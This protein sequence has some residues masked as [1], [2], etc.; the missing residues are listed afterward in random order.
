[1]C[2][3]YITK[4]LPKYSVITLSHPRSGDSQG[5]KRFLAP[6]ADMQTRKYK[7]IFK[8]GYTNINILF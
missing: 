7:P 8:F 2:T 6:S 5:Q 3:K 1:M 4:K